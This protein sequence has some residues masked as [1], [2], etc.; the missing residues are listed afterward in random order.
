MSAPRW[1]NR[2]LADIT[3][4]TRTLLPRS[5]PVETVR[6]EMLAGHAEGRSP[7]SHH[8]VATTL[9]RRRVVVFWTVNRHGN[10]VVLEPDN[11]MEVPS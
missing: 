5:T 8:G 10:A 1:T 2:C 11:V 3:V 4:T 7:T 9:R 6:C